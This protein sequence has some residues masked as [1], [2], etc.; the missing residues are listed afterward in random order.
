M[1]KLSERDAPRNGRRAALSP[2]CFPDPRAP[3]FPPP[4]LSPGIAAALAADAYAAYA[5]QPSKSKTRRGAA[6]NARRSRN[7]GNNS[8]Y[9][10]GN[11][12]GYKAG[13]A[14]AMQ[15]ARFAVQQ[16]QLAAMELAQ[17]KSAGAGPAAPFPSSHYVADGIYAGRDE[18]A[19]PQWTEPATP[20]AL[21]VQPAP[22]YPSAHYAD[23]VRS[24]DEAAR[25]N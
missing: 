18:A 25:L 21:R 24:A 8:G 23:L 1:L 10:A 22:L 20:G 12:A 15:Q 4:T 17:A 16:A 13:H 9:N 3:P 2:A 5:P 19:A 6:S 14:A 7:K 11:A